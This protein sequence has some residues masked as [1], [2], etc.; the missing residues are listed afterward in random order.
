MNGSAKVQLAVCVYGGKV[1]EGLFVQARAAGR[2]HGV[3]EVL[4]GTFDGRRQAA[5]QDGV[6]RITLAP[7][8]RLRVQPPGA[9]A[10][11]VLGRAA[12]VLTRRGSE[13][14]P[15]FVHTD[16][17]GIAELPLMKAPGCCKMGNRARRRNRAPCRAPDP[18]R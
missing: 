4:H 5:T 15:V 1:M 6:L 11:T 17:L 12:V 18:A 14:G 10:V 8:Q 7:V 9:Y 2:A 3:G 13:E 16:A